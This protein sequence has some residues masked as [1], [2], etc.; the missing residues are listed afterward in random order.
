[1]AWPGSDVGT[2]NTDAGTDI[3]A[4]ARANLL[5]LM[6]KFNQLRNH[7][8]AFMQGL[9]GSADAAAA[10]ATLGVPDAF[11]LR[12]KIINGAMRTNLN[13]DSFTVTA[14]T[15]VPT[16]SGG[17]YVQSHWFAYSTGADVAVSTI[18]D[19]AIKRM[20]R[21]TGAAS[22]TGVGVGQRIEG[23][24]IQ[25]ILGGPVTLS[26]DMRNSLLT[27]VTWTAYHK[28][29]SNF[30]TIGAPSKIQI[31]TGTFTVGATKARHSATFTVPT[32]AYDGV[33]ILF[34]VGAQTS[35]TW[36]IGDVQLEGGSTATPF[37][38][39]HPSL[40][41]LLCE[42]YFQ[43]FVATHS[44]Y[45]AAGQKIKWSHPLYKIKTSPLAISVS[46]VSYT[47]SSGLYSGTSDVSGSAVF[48]IL[49][50]TVTATGYAECRYTIA[51]WSEIA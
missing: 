30:G 10:R 24:L 29:G 5:D 22:V 21:L 39:I 3:P 46:A 43:Y 49:E 7:V 13:G 15:A 18:Y 36:D 44:G 51:A 37:E 35:G 48:P 31:A 19:T 8:T 45:N 16:S 20:M 23:N 26:V 33:E 11:G 4:N 17:G 2:T 42:R 12:N 34:T 41:A 40:E 6:Q 38:V 27:T 50:L 28:S 1:M 14:G 25:D 9:L 47:N 32:A